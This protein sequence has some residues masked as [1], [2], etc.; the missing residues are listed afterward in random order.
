VFISA[1][2]FL[3]FPFSYQAVPWI[4]SL[5]HL[6][7]SA[8]I[9]LSLLFFVQMRYTRNRVWGA[10]SLLVALVAPFA[11]ENGILI[12]PFAVLIDLTTPG[13]AQRSGLRRLGDA[14]CQPAVGSGRAD[15][16]GP[17]MQVKDHAVRLRTG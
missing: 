8:L 15:T 14:G 17:A 6:T 16:I 5:S 3:L 12:M 2:L 9:L 1:T 7:V 11:H 13:L 10:A 4:G